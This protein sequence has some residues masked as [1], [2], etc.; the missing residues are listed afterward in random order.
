VEIAIPG[1]PPKSVWVSL[2]IK[3]MAGAC[4]VS[5]RDTQGNVLWAF[6]MKAGQW[7]GTL[8]AGNTFVVEASES[9]GNYWVEIG[10]QW[11]FVGTSTRLVIVACCFGGLAGIWIRRSRKV[12]SLARRI[13]ARRICLGGAVAV[14]SGLIL[15]PTVHEFGHYI[16][17]TVLGAE[18][19]E[20]VWTAFSGVEAHVSFSRLPEG[21]GP[22]MS[23]AGPILP[24]LVAA[25]LIAIWLA[26][27]RR[28]PWYLSVCLVVPSL[29]FLFTNVGCIFEMF[30]SGAHMNRLSSHLGL[31]GLARVAFE[32]LPLFVSMIMFVLVGRRIKGM[33]ASNARE[34]KE[35]P[36]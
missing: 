28:M 1:S 15:Y 13:G 26:F 24:T 29:V 23:A 21:V 25:V 9:E 35:N 17:G 11:G 4:T 34:E 33:T 14:V 7:Q 27:S 32:L 36:A 18:V 12:V 8:P 5:S 3:G 19:R 31:R 22:W 16:V 10:S 2:R 20:V 30:N 6:V